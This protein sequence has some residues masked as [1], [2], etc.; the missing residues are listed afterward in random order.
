MY[1]TVY[2]KENHAENITQFL[3]SSDLKTTWH[4]PFTR[5]WAWERVQPL[6]V[7][8]QS[9]SCPGSGRLSSLVGSVVNSWPILRPVRLQIVVTK[10]EI[11]PL[12]MVDLL[13][14]EAWNA[15]TAFLW[16][17]HTWRFFGYLINLCFFTLF[18][19]IS[20]TVSDP[21]CRRMLG[22]NSGLLWL[23]RWQLDVL[24][25][26][27]NLIHTRLDLIHTRRDLVR[28]G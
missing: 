13:F 14:L 24:T 4:C 16:Q 12:K 19:T 8:P 6:N 28:L 2:V 5:D 7:V 25:V 3:S 10:A 22:S 23:W 18:N 20:S 26:R 21:L 1:S 11:L 15:L 27:L 17:L 9:S